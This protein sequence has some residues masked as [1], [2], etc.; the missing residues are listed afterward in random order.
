M[1]FTIDRDHSVGK[2][3]VISLKIERKYTDLNIMIIVSLNANWIWLISVQSYSKNNSTGQCV[4]ELYL[5][6]SIRC[7]GIIFMRVH[8]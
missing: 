8:L 3:K 7:H 1:N 2:V 5:N 6:Y 4:H